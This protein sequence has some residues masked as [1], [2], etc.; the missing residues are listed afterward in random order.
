MI[1]AVVSVE[2]GIGKGL[3]AIEL[4]LGDSRVDLLF[5]C[6]GI[7]LSMRVT[8]EVEGGH[9]LLD[10]AFLRLIDDELLQLLLIAVRQAGNVDLSL[11]VHFEFRLCIWLGLCRGLY[12]GKLWLNVVCVC[13]DQRFRARSHDAL[14]ALELLGGLCFCS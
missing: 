3:C 2:N 13:L 14:G 12:S 6:L 11:G 7:C 1:L 9:T 4:A 5:I 8:V 10:L